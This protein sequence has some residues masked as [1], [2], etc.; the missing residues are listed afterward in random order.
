MGQF[1]IALILGS[2]RC[3]GWSN[4]LGQA[5]GSLAP[6]SMTF[7]SIQIGDLQLYHEEIEEN[8]PLEWMRFRSEVR[9]VDAVLFVTPE[10][11]RSIPAA[12]KNAVDIGSSP[13]NQ[14]IWA[15]KPAAIISFSPGRIGGFGA[16]HH[17]RQSLVF[18]D[19]P[20]MQ[21]PEVYLSEVGKLFTPESELLGARDLLADFLRA[22]QRWI[23]AVGGLGKKSGSS[24]T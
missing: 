1:N 7:Q 11:N 24:I 19:M 17:L 2:A 4:K 8:P 15:G 13:D 22:F 21:Q 16:N 18:L 14:S 6:T 20:V 3:N 23:A 9:A 5:I 12:L 10:Y